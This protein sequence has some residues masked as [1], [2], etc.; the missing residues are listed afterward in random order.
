MEDADLPGQG[1]LRP[2]HDDVR[3]PIAIHVGDVQARLPTAQVDQDRLAKRAISEVEE[4]RRG[5]VASL[6]HKNVQVPVAVEVRGS[7][8]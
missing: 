5:H 2:A 8:T 4:D 6:C 7:D 1:E 3:G